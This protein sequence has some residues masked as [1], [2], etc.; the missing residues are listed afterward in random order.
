[1]PFPKLIHKTEGRFKQKP[2]PAAY[3]RGPL[4]SSSARPASRLQSA[5]RIHVQ[6]I[7]LVPLTA[8]EPGIQAVPPLPQ[9]DEPGVPCPRIAHPPQLI[10]QRIGIGKPGSVQQPP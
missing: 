3:T 6:R 1:M 4:G 9:P 7:G 5:R 10:A 8:Q 2:P